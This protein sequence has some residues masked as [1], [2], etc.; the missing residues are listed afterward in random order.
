MT[1]V[2]LM[3]AACMEI[4]C[5]DSR[6]RG[7]LGGLGSLPSFS[8]EWMDG[9]WFVQTAHEKAS[10][11]NHVYREYDRLMRTVPAFV[12]VPL[13]SSHLNTI[14]HPSPA[15]IRPRA[16][17]FLLSLPENKAPTV[18]CCPPHESLLPSCSPIDPTI[19]RIGQA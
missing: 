18:P 9:S 8:P 2:A 14:D 3:S 13:F 11:L 5:V 4:S 7:T 16:C 6:T 12:P 19:P 17:L 1:P 15:L 10:S